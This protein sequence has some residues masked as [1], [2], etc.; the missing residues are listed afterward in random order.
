[1]Y[2][3]K[4]SLIAFAG[5]F[6]LIGVV[7][8]V[9]PTTSHGEGGV[10]QLAVGSFLAAQP[11][12]Q[13]QLWIDPSSLNFMRFDAFGKRNAALGLG[14]GTSIDGNM[15]VR[16][17]GGATERVIVVLNTRNALCWGFADFPSAIPAF[18]RS[19]AEVLAGT[20]PSLGDGMT[21]IAFTKPE[22][23]PLPNWNQVITSTS[24]YV[25]ESVTSAIMC[26]DGELRS[27]SG[28]PDGTRGFA[29]TTQ[30]GIYNAGVPGGCPLEHD[31]DCYPAEKVQFKAT[32]P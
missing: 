6:L 32:G 13:T 26:Q 5:L 25:L 18:G 3:L 7:A 27:G 1:M 22:G 14:L 31:A 29:Q 12:T 16:D 8:L 30:T 17:L 21:R 4:N 2:K 19:P 20:Q 9:A 10:Q 28:F 23:S 15:T 24:P 11:A